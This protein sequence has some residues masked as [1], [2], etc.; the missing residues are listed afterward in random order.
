[1]PASRILESRLPEQHPPAANHTLQ[2]GQTGISRAKPSA[3]LVKLDYNR[4]DYGIAPDAAYGNRDPTPSEIDFRLNCRLSEGGR[5]FEINMLNRIVHV[6]PCEGEHLESA[7][8]ETRS[9]DDARNNS[10]SVQK[11]PRAIRS[12]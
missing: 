2:R 7:G 12:S 8:G 9:A 10:G 1:M 6:R 11:T 5:I 4:T 3:S